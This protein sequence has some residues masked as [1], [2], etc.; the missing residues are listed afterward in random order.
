MFR[1]EVRDEGKGIPPEKLYEMAFK[2]YAWC[3]NPR[4][5]RKN[6]SNWVVV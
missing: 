6:S 3:W 2:R 1:L 4:Y 5:A